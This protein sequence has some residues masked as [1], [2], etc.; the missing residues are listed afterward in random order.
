MHM[1]AFDWTVVAGVMAV[2]AGTAIAANQLT[3]S[4]SDFLVAG[5]SV[6][7]YML[8]MAYGMEWLGA[9]VIVAM[10]ELYYTSGFPGMWWVML[11]TPFSVYV[12]ASGW[13]V[14]RYRE[15]RSLTIAQFL[16]TRY[17][18]RVRLAA[19]IISWT[20]GMITF[21]FFPQ[22][23]ARL[24]MSIIGLPE[25][26]DVAGVH[27]STFV[28]LSGLMILVPLSFIISGGHT[29]VIVSNFVQGLFTNIAAVIIVGVLLFTMFDWT[30]I[31]HTLSAVSKPDA[32]MFDPLHA[33]KS[34]INVWYFLIA[35]FGNTC[36]SA[37]SNVPS[38]AFFGSGKSAHEQRMGYLLNQI[39]WQGLLVFF[40]VVVLCAMPLIH[41]PKD[42]EAT[43]HIAAALKPVPP[44]MHDKVAV[45][46]ALSY[47]LPAGLVGLFCAI[48]MAALISSHN[49]FMHAWGGVLLQ[50]I[51]LPFRKEPLG[52]RAHLWALRGAIVLVGLLAFVLA[53]G[54]DSKQSILMLFASVNNI[55]LG[56]AGAVMLGG[57]YWK[58]GT[59]KAALTTLL[60]GAAL[61]TAFFV[62][63][64][65]WSHVQPLLA[66]AWPNLPADEFPINGAFCFLINIIFSIVL[67]TTVSLLTCRQDFNMYKLLHRGAYAVPG[68][69]LPTLRPTRWWQTI[70]GITPMFNRRDRIT[71]Y[72]VVGYFL[73]WLAVFAIGMIYGTLYHPGDAVW[74]Q[75]WHVYIYIS[76]GLLL[77]TTVWLG[78]G[79]LRDLASLFRSL[80]RA[81]RDYSDTGEMAH[82]SATEPSA[83]NT[84]STAEVGK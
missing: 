68:E 14:Y 13:G 53:I 9:I 10:F 25:S 70:F 3:K 41:G 17:D 48:M 42:S 82:T 35:F 21:G 59:S 32:S 8:T 52:T 22:Y 49:S 54:S 50:D 78:I 61:G 36:Y 11:T 63:L 2:F 81:D 18:R 44:E 34:K 46:S 73:V 33:S 65:F 80:R 29:S 64:Q 20:A 56:P 76:T 7:R 57:L 79:G 72:L 66:R 60:A 67:Y 16:E 5:R 19:G 75:F 24:F 55:W 45:A 15:T 26:F 27:C 51:I 38:Q 83:P 6:G 69:E 62:C 58:K 31:T 74:A 30:N 1:T 40:M 71:A 4:V 39:S 77:V 12:C 37:M 23:S 28:V 84:V 47:M 43:N